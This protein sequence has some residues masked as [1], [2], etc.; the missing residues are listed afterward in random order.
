MKAT[1]RK[2][3]TRTALDYPC[4]VRTCRQPKG[5]PCIDGIIP[6]TGKPVVRATPHDSRQQIANQFK[7]TGPGRKPGTPDRDLRILVCG[8]RDWDDATVI[9]REMLASLK[10]HH[11]TTWDNV[12][13]ITG[14][15]NGADKLCEYL[16]THEFGCAVAVFPAPWD[17][18][19]KGGRFKLLTAGPTRNAWMLR[20]GTP[21]EVLAFHHYLPGSRGTKRMVEMAGKAGVSRI[22]V[23]SK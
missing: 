18:Y 8:A 10:R 13:V 6:A 12:L 20:W 19:R 2:R 17:A 15:A 23:V 14:G 4:P 16:C 3:P 22:K 5:S 9:E 7:G 1:V 11:K 21:D